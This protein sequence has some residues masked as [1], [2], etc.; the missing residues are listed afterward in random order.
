METEQA[1]GK[2]RKRKGVLVQSAQE[3][4]HSDPSQLF[5]HLVLRNNFDV[6]KAKLS[7]TASRGS[8]NWQWQCTVPL[9]KRKCMRQ[10][11]SRAK[12]EYGSD[13]HIVAG[14]LTAVL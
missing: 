8:C 1:Q 14:I 11:Q 7:S 5:A 2:E 10:E 12:I 6:A 4:T 13:T 3:R 9:S